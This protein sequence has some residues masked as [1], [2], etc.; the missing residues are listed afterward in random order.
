MNLTDEFTLKCLKGTPILFEDVCMIYPATLGQIVDEGY[1]KFQQYLSIITSEKPLF[2]KKEDAELTELI[3]NLTDF[4]YL[5]VLASLDIEMNQLLKNAF[6]FFT[7][8]NISFS[9]SPAQIIIGPLEEQHILSEDNFYDFQKIIK[10]MFFLESEG[11]DIVINKNDS[12][13]VKRLKMK[14]RENRKK[15]KKAK[16]KK[17]SANDG[18]DMKFSDLLASLTINDC[19]L[20]ISNIWDI[21]YY[22]FNDQLKRMGWRDQ[23]EI[24]NRAALAGAKIKKEQLK[25]WMKSINVDKN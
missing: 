20:N 12:D 4:Q 8:E 11:D 14:M 17:N 21:T 22:A 7:K 2:N 6:Y 23:F 24:N 1:D 16:Q 3:K 5:L 19:G 15:V 9:I 18:S 10:R 25:H 13:A